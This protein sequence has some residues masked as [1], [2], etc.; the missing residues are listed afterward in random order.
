MD[1]DFDFD[2]DFDGDGG[3]G[4]LLPAVIIGRLFDSDKR[5]APAPA[6]AAPP[7]PPQTV[8]VLRCGNC[9]KT[10]E[11]AFQFC[12]HCGESAQRREC[13]YCGRDNAASA[14]AC[15]GCGAPVQA[16]R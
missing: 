12:P 8:M 10:Y 4:W 13:R 1:F 9:Q 3:L 2:F 15:L 6:Q 5:R 11:A 16:A 7:P 14:R